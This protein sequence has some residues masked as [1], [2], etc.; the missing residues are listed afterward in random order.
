MGYQTLIVETKN[1]VATITLNRPERYNAVNLQL[2]QELMEAVLGCDEDPEVR[3]LVITGTGRAFSGGGDVKEF[4]ERLEM[5]SRY[6]KELT[7]I[8]HT[9][10]SRICRMP[11]PVLAAVNGVAA[12]GGMS[13]ALACDLVVAAESARFTMAYAGIG[14]TPDGSSSYFLPRLVGLKR[15]LEL[16]YT[17]RTLTAREAEAWGLVNKVVPDPDFK[18]AVDELAEELAQGPTQ[19]FGRAK[20]LLHLG[21][22]ESLETQMEHESQLIALSGRTEDFREGVRAFLEKRKASFRGR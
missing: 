22:L 21:S 15:A 1:H 18:A 4:G 16:V 5:A 2:A 6:L 12:G 3:M 13:L 10:I 19:A 17:N 14:A 11:K 7:T 9:A 8:L 20:R